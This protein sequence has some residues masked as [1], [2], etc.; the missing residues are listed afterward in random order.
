MR[1]SWP[2]EGVVSS[3]LTRWLERCS[4]GKIKSLERAITVMPNV[5]MPRFG[6]W[7]RQKSKPAVRPCT[8]TW[9][10]VVTSVAPHL[11]LIR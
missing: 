10:L 9:S 5:I 1:Y 2:A 6:R 11:A 8:S 4:F 3:V 7:N